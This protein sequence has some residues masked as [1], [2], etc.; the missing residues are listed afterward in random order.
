[1]TSRSDSRQPQSGFTLVEVLVT[2]VIVALVSGVVF[3]SLQQV[4]DA[5]ARLRPYLD[6]SEE[7][8]LGSDWFRKT[9]QAL[10][11]DYEDGQHLF[12]GSVKDLSG[13]A[14]SPLLGPPGTPT[15]FRWQIKQNTEEDRTVLEYQENSRAVPI[16]SWA[17]Q[18]GAFTYYAEDGK[19]HN[20][21]PP[22]DID[23]G[24]SIPQ[25]PQ[26][27]RFSGMAGGLALTIVAAPHA[28]RVAPRPP[29]PLLS[30]R[31]VQ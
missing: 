18:D 3:G 7:I 19:W 20:S 24:K 10:L 6:N 1:M 14:G 13:L 25:L 4:F 8:T 31:R 27:V 26:L 29:P 2:L 16:L 12:A 15:S 22:R 30:D 5:R 11:A 28:S 17:G 23:Q 21:W 9:V